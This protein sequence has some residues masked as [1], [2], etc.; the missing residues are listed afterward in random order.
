MNKPSRRRTTRPLTNSPSKKGYHYH[1]HKK[2]RP[3][4]PR[5]LS[6]KS[7]WCALQRLKMT[8]SESTSMTTTSTTSSSTSPMT[9]TTIVEVTTNI[10]HE[11]SHPPPSAT[12]TVKM[13]DK[14]DK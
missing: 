7:S 10:N 13:E 12:I 14:D 2:K 6:E 11:S 4:E 9:T 8:W 3:M 5:I 1:L